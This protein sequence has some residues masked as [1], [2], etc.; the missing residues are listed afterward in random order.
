MLVVVNDFAWVGCLPAANDFAWVGYLAA[1]HDYARVGYLA[2]AND[3]TRANEKAGVNDLAEVKNL[4]KGLVLVNSRRAK[5]S[6]KRVPQAKCPIRYGEPCTACQPGTN[7]PEDC[8]LVQLVMD[9]EELR[10]RMH[11]MNRR[12]ATAQRDPQKTTPKAR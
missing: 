7:G 6:K 5:S 12:M 2:A 4:D 3:S 10:E 9:D 11:E 1:A 8:Q